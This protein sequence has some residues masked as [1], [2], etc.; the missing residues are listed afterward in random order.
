MSTFLC[1]GAAFDVSNRKLTLVIERVTKL[2][3]REV[4]SASLNHIAGGR[5][6]IH[7]IVLQIKKLLPKDFAGGVRVTKN[8]RK[9]RWPHF[10]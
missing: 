6:G 4:E 9:R 3:V 2:K 8:A 5:D 1:R 10:K 7:S